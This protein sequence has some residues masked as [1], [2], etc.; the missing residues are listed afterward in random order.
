[1]NTAEKLD[2]LAEL[3]AKKDLLNYDRAQEIEKLIPAE[4]QAK[5]NK[6]NVDFDES[7]NVVNSLIDEIKAEVES[8]VLASAEKKTVKGQWLMACYVKGRAG[9]W[10]SGKL[11][12]YAL[13]HPEILSA[14]KPDGAPTV[15]F[16]AVGK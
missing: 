7:L 3:M 16:R 2:K 1:M 4:V 9:G 11:D 8:E 14:K 5:I 12:G 13:A 15:Q 10:D 6:V